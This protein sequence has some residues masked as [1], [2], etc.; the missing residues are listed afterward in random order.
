M[1]RFF[2]SIRQSLLAQGRVT[3]YLTYAIGEIVLVMVGI[4]L[5][6]QV[7]TWNQDRQA[8]RKEQVLLQELHEEFVTNKAQLEEVISFHR[9]AMKSTEAVI[10]EFPITVDSLDLD[11]FKVHSRDMGYR[12]T[13][14]PSQGIINSLVNTSSFDLITDTE[15]RKLLVSWN[16][17]L[18]DYQEEEIIATQVL[19]GNITPY[20]IRHFAF[21]GGL[22]DPR[23]DLSFLESTEY[24]NLV[25]LRHMNLKDI[26]GTDGANDEL[27]VI[28]TTI[29]RI[30]DLSAP[31]EE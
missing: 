7:S 29:D 14:N 16:D 13:F 3:R 1:I 28:Q 26:L 30:I 8:R 2:R 18:A 15:L 6:L 11:S 4:L 24:E 27:A 9:R 31:P 21:F 19:I 17:V 22:Q 23:L 5:A 12:Y 25:I 10:A 20:M